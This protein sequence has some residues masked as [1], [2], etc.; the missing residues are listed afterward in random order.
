MTFAPD[1]HDDPLDLD[2]ARHVAAHAVAHLHFG[3]RFS[4]L[5]AH[6][7]GRWEVIDPIWGTDRATNARV[8]LAG[9]CMDVTVELI[10]E[11]GDSLGIGP[12]LETWRVDVA[13]IHGYG[14]DMISASGGVADAAS[15]S[16]AFCRV[17]F[18][19]IDELAM[20]VLGGG[21]R[22][23]YDTLAAMFTGRTVDVDP[24]ALQEADF[25][26]A[27]QSVALERVDEAV[28]DRLA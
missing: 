9:P 28:A 10:E 12:W 1:R 13:R 8:A 18:D 27:G 4:S 6:A 5:G 7:A 19:V 23:D 26:F 2:E 15:W 25:D 21:A 11:D 14:Y 16:L 20:M 17:N 24:A 3:Q 22:V